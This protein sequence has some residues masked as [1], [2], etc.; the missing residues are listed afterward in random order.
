MTPR[1][2][3]A[4]RRNLDRIRAHLEPQGLLNVDPLFQEEFALVS[5]APPFVRVG[6]DYKGPAT[7]L[8]FDLH[9]ASP[10]AAT[11][12]LQTSGPLRLSAETP[13]PVHRAPD[14]IKGAYDIPPMICVRMASA[15]AKTFMA[16]RDA[17]PRKYLAEKPRPTSAERYGV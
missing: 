9:P 16:Y 12:N 10:W 5:A 2:P 15:I 13:R 6:L 3:A 4:A 17:P 11:H 1:N 14:D 8:R 7:T